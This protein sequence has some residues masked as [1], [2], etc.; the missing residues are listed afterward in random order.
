MVSMI[1]PQG[2]KIWFPFAETLVSV[3][4]ALA[5]CP[6]DL[7]DCPDWF[8]ILLW[9]KP[10]RAWVDGVEE[11]HQICADKVEIFLLEAF[12][13]NHVIDA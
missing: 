11:D 3:V 12:F 4:S 2:N 13:H 9:H 7:A 6:K 5:L 8:L 10:T 1:L